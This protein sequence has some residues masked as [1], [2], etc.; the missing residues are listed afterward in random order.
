MGCVVKL[1]AIC[2]RSD[3]G[4]SI[5]VRVHPVMLPREHPLASVKGAYN[6]V[7]VEAESAGQLMFYGAGAGGVPTASAVL[8]DLVA[9]ARNRLAR[10]FVADGRADAKLPVHPMGETIT[11]YHVALDV[12]D[13][14]GV[15]AGVA[16]VFA[17]NACRSSVRQEARGDDTQL[18]L[19]NHTAPMP[20]WPGPWSNCATTRTSA[21]SPARAGRNLRQRTMSA[22][23][24]LASAAA[25][26][27]APRGRCR[28]SAAFRRAL[29][30]GAD[31]EL[32]RGRP[33]GASHPG[34]ATAS[35]R[36]TSPP[37]ERALS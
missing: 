30:S 32:T 26:A 36:P 16:K 12:A 34:A 13:R 23:P 29:E 3:D 28:G 8:G 1:L 14:P 37:F 9:V 20:P 15:L 19:V 31:Y 6:A 27:A 5:G 11:S 35:G 17:A 4:S 10:T 33:T 22:R 7:F 25:A 2:Q 18:V 24:V 21:R